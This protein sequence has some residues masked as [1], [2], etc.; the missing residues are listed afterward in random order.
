MG[1]Q[2]PEP[3]PRISLSERIAAVGL[4]LD[5]PNTEELTLL[6]QY[7]E[8]EKELEFFKLTEFCTV[9]EISTAELMLTLLKQRLGLIDN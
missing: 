5:N 4:L 8:I 1:E 9:A 6:M 3:T 7:D 2:F